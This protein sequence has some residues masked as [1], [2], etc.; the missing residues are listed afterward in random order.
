ML[1]IISG[2]GTE[3]SLARKDV[4]GIQFGSIWLLDKVI[5]GRR[6][7][8]TSPGIGEIPAGMPFQE[9]PTSMPTRVASLESNG[10]EPS[11]M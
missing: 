11:R 7:G 9:F 2:G 3:M 1:S 10:T 8:L 5:I 6:L 4:L